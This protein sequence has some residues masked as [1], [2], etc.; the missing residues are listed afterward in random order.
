MTIDEPIAPAPQTAPRG[1]SLGNTDGATPGTFIDPA[2]VAPA[3]PAPVAT[4]AL[5]VPEPAPAPA[6]VVFERTGDPGLDTA[7]KFFAEAGMAPESPEMQ[8]AKAGDLLPLAAK[9]GTLG[10]KARGFEGY[11]ALAKA[12][13][14]RQAQAAAQEAQALLTYVGGQDAWA[15]IQSW[16]ASNLDAAQRAQVNTALKQGGYIAQL[17]IDGLRSK[18]NADPSVSTFGAEARQPS[19]VRT[20]GAVA[21]LSASEFAQEVRKLRQSQGFVDGTTAYDALVRR[22]DAGRKAGL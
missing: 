13:F 6:P 1:I 14:D 19:A 16:A 7:L 20:P 12:S 5:T 11:I 10:D 21:G 9:L 8:A 4:P 17:A 3:A 2:P 18:I 15:G 22:R